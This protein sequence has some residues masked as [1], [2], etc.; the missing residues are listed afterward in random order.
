[1]AETSLKYTDFRIYLDRDA[2]NPV[3]HI[4]SSLTPTT[5][6]PSNRLSVVTTPVEVN[7]GATAAAPQDARGA[8]I[9]VIWS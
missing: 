7:V 8:Q 4:D 1:M 3:G 5:T 2:A 6:D 9:P